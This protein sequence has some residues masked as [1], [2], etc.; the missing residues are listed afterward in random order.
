MFTSGV[1][2]PAVSEAVTFYKIPPRHATR[3][4]PRDLATGRVRRRYCSR[5]VGSLVWRRE[6]IVSKCSTVFPVDSKLACVDGSTVLA[7]AQA[8]VDRPVDLVA[9]RADRAVAKHKVASAGVRAAKTVH[10]GIARRIGVR[11]IADHRRARDVA[12]MAD[13]GAAVRRFLR[14][15][16]SRA[17]SSFLRSKRCCSCRRNLGHRHFAGRMEDA[18]GAGGDRAKIGQRA[19]QVRIRQGKRH[20]DVEEDATCVACVVGAGRRSVTLVKY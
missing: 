4:Q 5:V 8:G 7:I 9:N 15:C 14:R 11:I 17:R 20:A 2:F 10:C 13:I 3:S 16:R 19:G 1:I 18:N 6:N 12:V